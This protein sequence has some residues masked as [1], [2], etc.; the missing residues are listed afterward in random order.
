MNT[1]HQKWVWAISA[2]V[3]VFLLGLIDWKTGYEL[4]FFV[5]YFIPV[6][7]AAWLFGLG[8]GVVLSVLSA[9]MWFG[10]DALSGH[11][12]T[13]SVYAVWNTIIRFVS[14]LA[15]GAAVA[16]MQHALVNERRTA[17][18]LR[19]ALSEVKVLE[20]FIPICAQCK[21]I[22]NQKGEWEQLESYIGQ[23]THTQF[24]HG[25]CPDCA[26]KFLEEAGLTG[27]GPVT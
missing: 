2:G 12:Y 1:E 17:S 26:R 19:Q 24:S 3:G 7:I 6:S 27:K 13:S 23:R 14:F 25:Y 18:S 21:K 9:L 15:I 11:V 10:A 22:R 16:K 8:G 4:N 5:F 20:S